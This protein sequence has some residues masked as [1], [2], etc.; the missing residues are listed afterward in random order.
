MWAALTGFAVLSGLGAACRTAVEPLPARA[1]LLRP[2]AVYARWWAMTEACA[3]TTGD[4]PAVRWYQVPGSQFTR[5]DEPVGGYWDARANRII[6]A[7]A[8][9]ADGAAVRHEM[10]HAIRRVGGHPRAQ[11][12]GSC[13]PLVSCQGACVTDAGPWRG[14]ASS[15]SLPPDSL[16]V[17]SRADLL[18]AEA[19]GQRWIALRVTVRNVRGDAVVVAAPGN[20]LTPPTFG[21]DIRA[22]TGGYAGNQVATDSST[23]V[24]RPFE[25]KQWLYEFLITSE[26]TEH[27]VPR[28]TLLIRGG[29]A[30][31]WA[32]YDT[33][34]TNP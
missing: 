20:A 2:P 15:R 7:A 13:A 32:E 18:P 30:R 25:T 1:E 19:D 11:F 3:G 34:R 31:R 24:F 10:L 28:G 12:L 9:V 22:P 26:L 16:D 23:L 8:L 5:G 21:Y 6:L 4:L 33:V 17:A 27:G 29:Y 14:P